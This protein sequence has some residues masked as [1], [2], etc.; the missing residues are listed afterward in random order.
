MRVPYS[1]LKEY[2]EF[3]E[4]PGEIANILTMTGTK[5]E[6]VESDDG[7]EAVLDL[8]ITP[9]R[10]DCLSV[11]GIAREIAA[12]LGRPLK[13]V[14]VAA[15]GKGAATRELVSVEIQDPELAPR[16][17]A[18]VIRNVKVGPSPLWMQKRLKACGIRPICNVVDITNYVMLECGQ[19]LHAFDYDKIRGHKIIVRRAK[20]GEQIVT[21]DGETRAL[22]RDI[23]VIADEDT[24]VAIAGV[25]GG[26]D[27]EVTWDTST[28][29]LESANFSGSSIWRTSKRLKLRTEASLRFDKGLDPELAVLGQSMACELFSR[30]GVGEVAS[31]WVD[32]YPRPEA[33][34]MFVLDPGRV[35]RLLGVQLTPGDMAALLERLQIPAKV[36]RDGTI[37]V[38]V[39]GFRRD[40]SI[41]ADFV[42]EIARLYGYERVAA[43]T[44]EGPLPERIEAPFAPIET[45]SREIMLRLGLDE[46]VTSSLVGPWAFD[47][48]NLPAESPLKCA[49]KIANPLAEDESML[50]TTLIPSIVAV[51]RRNSDRDVPNVRCFEIGRVYIPVEGGRQPEER[52]IL[53][54]GL[55]G[56]LPEA[57]WGVERRKID[58]FD[59]KGIIEAYLDEVGVEDYY[60]ERFTHPSLHP[61]RAALIWSRH[62]EGPPR[63]LGFL[64]E[65]SP[66]V[67]KNC[68]FPSRVYVFE[69]DLGTIASLASPRKVAL[70]P[71]RF[72]AVAR[73]IAMVVPLD[74]SYR[75][76][77]DAIRDAAGEL[78]EDVTLFDEYT[79]PQVPEGHHSLAFRMVLR[80]REKTLTDEEANRVWEAVAERVTRDCKATVRR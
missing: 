42:E 38:E 20:P 51:L 61:G 37:A 74:V 45:S 52:R 21:L 25:M 26:L 32:V 10:P 67:S 16:Y 80:A 28:V 34:R 59:A 70:E 55:M 40:L 48:I 14:P 43:T 66:E 4:S 76:V 62:G 53:A 72:P 12:A 69:L 27:T 19:P 24:P 54:G 9:N 73:D 41:E 22:D 30:L 1:W 2:V 13:F 71:P 36:G 63:E 46:V 15:E 33:P 31:G 47:L 50:R 8:E 65:L 6:S 18:R 68:G 39:P 75:H 77:E 11:I 49:V 35:N 23:L 78:L 56:N 3:D 17:I 57:T 44:L 58:F 60:F 79:G 7:G 5:V 29:L 64:G